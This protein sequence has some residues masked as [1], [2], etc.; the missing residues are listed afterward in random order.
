MK[1]SGINALVRIPESQTLPVHPSLQN[2]YI[3]PA[4]CVH[5]ATATCYLV[6]S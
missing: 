3:F 5:K 2:I 4:F 1:E 6:V